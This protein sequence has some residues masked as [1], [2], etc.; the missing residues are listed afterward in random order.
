MTP[1]PTAAQPPGYRPWDYHPGV[2][3]KPWIPS[4]DTVTANVGTYAITGWWVPAVLDFLTR[5]HLDPRVLTVNPATITIGNDTQTY[6][7]PANLATDLGTTIAGVNG[8]TLGITYS[9]TGDMERE[10]VGAYAIPGGLGTG[11]T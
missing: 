11:R 9:S 1:K 5:C 6:G 3:G 8:E 4:G 10:N 7:S 2:N